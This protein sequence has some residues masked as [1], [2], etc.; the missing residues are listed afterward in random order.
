MYLIEFPVD[1]FSHN[2]YI[3]TWA[4]KA[5]VDHAEL[6]HT[7][8]G[9]VQDDQHHVCCVNRMDKVRRDSLDSKVFVDLIGILYR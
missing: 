7:I 4:A 9:H 8:G 3:I 2:R 5:V 1:C 6:G